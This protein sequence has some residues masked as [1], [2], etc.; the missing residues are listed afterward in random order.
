MGI[1]YDVNFNLMKLFH[2]KRISEFIPPLY[3][4]VLPVRRLD[5]TFQVNMLELISTVTREVREMIGLTIAL[6]ALYFIFKRCT[7]DAEGNEFCKL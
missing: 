4:D 1:S 7:R 2:F 3:W 5:C 6:I